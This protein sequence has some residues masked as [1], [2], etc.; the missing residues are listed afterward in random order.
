MQAM[1]SL[2]LIVVTLGLALGVM[3]PVTVQAVST[4]DALHK[5]CDYTP[6]LAGCDK[7]GQQLDTKGSS[8]TTYLQDFTDVFFLAAGTLAVIFLIL[9]GI[10]Y[11]TSSG[12]SARIKAAK[13]T[14]LYAI[15]G[16]IVT[17]LAF[18]IV[19]FVL[20]KIGS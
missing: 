18:P 17:I 9:G 10:R 4:S 12:D 13:D 20:A 7:N 2:L 3:A 15:I 6:G 8:S 5:A 14:I 16:L 11:I 19:G 1:K